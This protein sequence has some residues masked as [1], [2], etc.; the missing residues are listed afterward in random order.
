MLD[1]D[2]QRELDFDGWRELARRDPARFERLRSRAIEQLI[3]RAPAARRQRL[4]GLQWRIDAA[5]ARSRTPL[6]ATLR[7]SDMM[8]ESFFE[9]DRAFQRLRAP[10]TAAPEVRAPGQLLAFRRP[11]RA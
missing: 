8:W 5:R 7:I 3:E 9:L 2:L 6:A 10:D 1:A 11:P 4:R